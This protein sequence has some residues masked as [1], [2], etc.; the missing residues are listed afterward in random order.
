MRTGAN[1]PEPASIGSGVILIAEDEEMVRQLMVASVE[2]LGYRTLAAVDGEEAVR[3]FRENCGRITG[4]L[5][6]LKMP[7]KGG[8]AAF[9]EIR[10]I[11]PAMPVLICSGYGDN[12]EA[13]SLIAL[14]AKGLLPKPFRLSELAVHLAALSA[15]G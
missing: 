8:Y 1:T 15:R 9:V 2:G 14:G 4:V 12:E 7:R 11:D 3:L 13:Q 10:E 5:L 6:D